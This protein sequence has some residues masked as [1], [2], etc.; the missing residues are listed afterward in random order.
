[1]PRGPVKHP[2]PCLRCRAMTYRKTQV[3]SVCLEREDLP[4]PVKWSE[5]Y[6]ERCA[7]ELLKRHNERHRLLVQLGIKAEAA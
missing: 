2:R 7:Q 6:L 4:D 3:C 5:E 1:M